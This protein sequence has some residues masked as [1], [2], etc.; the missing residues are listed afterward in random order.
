VKLVGKLEGK[1]WSKRQ[2]EEIQKKDGYEEGRR[3][4]T[5]QERRMT[6]APC[7]RCGPEGAQTGRTLADIVV[8]TRVRWPVSA[9]VI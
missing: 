6:V 5:G 9:A 8:S 4:R 7:G 3:A 1:E 2:N